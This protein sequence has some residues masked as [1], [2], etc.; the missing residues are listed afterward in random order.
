MSNSTT[1]K[2]LQ[3]IAK[4]WDEL[5]ENLVKPFALQPDLNDYLKKAIDLAVE[6]SHFAEKT[7]L[8]LSISASAQETINLVRDVADMWKHG[9][10]RKPERT[11]E[12]HTAACF[13]YHSDG[14]F[15]F[16]C[17]EVTVVH[18]TY[19]DK[20]FLLVMKEHITI[21]QQALPTQVRWHPVIRE[22]TAK[23]SETAIL[24][25]TPK[26]Q[27]TLKNTRL[28]MFSQQPDGSKIPVDP[29]E[30]RFEML[31]HSRLPPKTHET[32]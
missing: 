15:A 21:I 13:W 1:D 25:Y 12:L 3:Y 17:N 4:P 16:I 9:Q 10:L 27:I 32:W 7:G 5:N 29:T 14:K 31:E 22:A 6:I 20:N 8:T 24:Y 11:N 19:G 26:T 2:F 18:R 23:Y 28:K 30:V